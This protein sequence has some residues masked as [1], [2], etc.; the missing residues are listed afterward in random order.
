MSNFPELTNKEV[1]AALVAVM[2]AMI[3][4][5]T[6]PSTER[7]RRLRSL[8]ANLESSLKP[9]EPPAADFSLD[10]H[11]VDVDLHGGEGE[12]LAGAHRRDRE[13]SDRHALEPR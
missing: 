6:F 8:L 1:G 9:T 13:E 5:E 7:L 11:T 10:L 2:R 4:K 3:A 12:E